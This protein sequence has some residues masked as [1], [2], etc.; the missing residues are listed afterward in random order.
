MNTLTIGFGEYSELDAKQ[1]NARAE[2][3]KEFL[4]TLSH[5]EKH[6]VLNQKLKE[7]AKYEALED[8]IDYSI[9]I[10]KRIFEISKAF[11]IETYEIVEALTNIYL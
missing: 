11:N 7:I 10:D 2:G 8:N 5:Y 4:S 6:E 9:E 3:L 1:L